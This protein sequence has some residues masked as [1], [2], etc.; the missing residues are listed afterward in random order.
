M[1]IPN[2]QS[3]LE[4]LQRFLPHAGRNYSSRRNYVSDSLA[5]ANV[6]GLSPWVRTR[7]LQEWE[8]I[9][10]VL[11]Q[12]SASAASK[13][14]EEVCWR[15]Y[16]K[17]WLQ[18]RPAVWEQYLAELNQARSVSF[19]D[20]TYQAL[21]AGQSGIECVD[22][23]T[24]ELQ[25]TGYLHNHVRMW[26]ASIWIHTL[27]LP[28]VLGADLFM[29]YLLDG[30]PASNTLSW[31]WVA[32]LHTKG[33]TY[34]AHP[35]NIQKYTQGRI[36]VKERLAT[37]A[38]IP[39]SLPTQQP[40]SLPSLGP[41]PQKKLRVGVLLLEDD[42][43]ALNWLVTN[44]DKAE[45]HIAGYFSPAV[46]SINKIAPMVAH[47]RQESLKSVLQADHPLFKDVDSV[48]N[49]A[50]TK[51]LDTVLMAEVPIGIWDSKMQ[52][53]KSAVEAH[54]VKL[55]MQRS[56]WDAYFYPLAKAG[57]FRFKQG[58]PAA[59]HSVVSSS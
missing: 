30:D 38:V 25:Q 22:Q 24:Q 29:Q 13:F 9:E 36:E 2:R 1:H 11:H 40:P 48:G 50:A 42:V 55:S 28:W 34:L 53:L 26:Y 10:H 8:I 52:D 43:R 4:V 14:I 44:Q 12:H 19:M 56:P 7:L 15:T 54:G 31:R 18:L 16:W 5:E 37:E 21:L 45:I 59:L 41:L 23:W 32:G 20:S 46:Y 17:G 3:A 35:D 47:F 39:K 49:W 27:K 6:S 58:I 33:K 51:Q 57:F